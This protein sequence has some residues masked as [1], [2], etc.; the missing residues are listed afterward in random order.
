MTPDRPIS[1]AALT[2]WAKPSPPAQWRRRLRKGGESD[3]D[4]TSPIRSAAAFD[5]EAGL[6]GRCCAEKILCEGHHPS[7]GITR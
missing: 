1:L 4:P 6:I 5:R 2:H 3:D 7:A